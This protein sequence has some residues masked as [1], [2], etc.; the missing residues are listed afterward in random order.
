[1]VF[2]SVI[3]L[4]LF[5]P[6]VLSVYLLIR[7]DFRNAFILI[8][9]L[10]FY[11][12]GE[13]KYVIIM[14]LYMFFNYF[15]GLY[16][17]K[18]KHHNSLKGNSYAE[19]TLI[20][21]IIFNL[22]FLIFF[23][24]FNFLVDNLNF[25]LKPFNFMINAPKIHLP[26]G[27]SFFTF[28]ALSYVIDI[29][30]KDVKAQKSL[31]TFS[32]YK[33]LFPQLIAGPIVRYRDVCSQVE[34]RIIDADKFVEGIKRFV[35]GLGKKVIIANTVASV[36]DKIF[37]IQSAK[38]TWEIA[39]LG[40]I[41]YTLQIYFD[42][43]GYS[44][45]A[46]GLGKMF[47]FDFLEN[48]N[49]PYISKSI[50]EFW[51][52]W[53]ISLSSWFRDYVYIPLGGNRVGRNRIYLNQIIVFFLCG[54]WHGASWTFVVWGLWHGVFLVIERTRFGK[55]LDCAFTPIKYIYTILVVLIGWVLFRSDSLGYGLTFIGAMF[56]FGKGNGFEN[57]IAQFIN[58]ELIVC[59][60]LGI[61]FSTPIIHKFKE[62]KESLIE[63]A[64]F[65]AGDKSF[66]ISKTIIS[67][68]GMA[69][70]MVI[71][72]YCSVLLASGTHNPFIY[73]RF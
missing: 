70:Y 21:S 44:D 38:L 6:I 69:I 23:K 45:M 39:W 54:L 68:F 17:E 65:V 8:S 72:I 10:F 20:L 71:F 67:T 12:W 9:S 63:K 46:I 2:S 37:A 19:L 43:G 56:G 7:K 51:K 52:R 24:Y 62:L 41:C 31:I 55:L 15:F 61:V 35:I 4:F 29:Y 50:K 48:F 11:F 22:G 58:P 13:G 28:Q 26:I 18:Y 16:I 33:A 57:N 66:V 60:I 47:G 34:H 36:A 59:L 32:M 40:I 53:H 3:F 1:M 73:F 14:I 64:S 5:L 27:I 42:F 30:R 25:V 49:Y